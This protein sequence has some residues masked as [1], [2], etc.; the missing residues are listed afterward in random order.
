MG[1]FFKI[2]G[3]EYEIPQSYGELTFNQLYKWQKANDIID[4]IEAFS[5]CPRKILE[6]C[7][8]IQLDSKILPALEWTK[9]EFDCDKLLIP[10]YLLFKGNKYKRPS[11]LGSMTFGQK[12]ELQ[13]AINEAEKSAKSD[14]DI[15]PFALAL[16]FQ[17]QIDKVEVYNIDCVRE[18][19]KEIA[20]NVK[21]S[22]G[23]PL[24]SFFLINYVQYVNVSMNAFGQNIRK[25]SFMQELKAYKSLETLEQLSPW[26][27]LCVKLLSKF[28]PRTTTQYSLPSTMSRK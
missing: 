10:D 7:E 25:K 8:D 22:N 4:L 6:R 23:W 18:L 2:S 24:A 20:E 21:L 3:K 12:I 5:K 27:R 26:R 17:P 15:M 14:A 28:W 9:S 1:F 13:N 19:E 16:Y 11:G